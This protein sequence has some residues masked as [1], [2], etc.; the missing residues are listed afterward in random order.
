MAGPWEKYKQA[1]AR[2]VGPQDPK[3]PLDVE[4]KA[5]A[6]ARIPV[7]T[8]GDEL[9]NRQKEQDLRKGG[10]LGEQ[11]QK[12]LNEMRAQIG[13]A[14]E[15]VR[16]LSD[17]AGA[18]DRFGGGPTKAKWTKWGTAEEGG[19]LLDMLGALTIGMGIP[20]QQKEDWQTLTGLQNDAV[21]L[22]Q[23]A[24]K[25]PQTESDAVRMQLASLSPSKYPRVNAQTIGAAALNARLLQR[26]PSFYTNWAAKH[27]SINALDKSGRTVDQAWQA[28]SGVA[29]NAYKNDPRVKGLKAN[30]GAKPKALPNGWKIERA[31]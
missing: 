22:K 3:A 10:G 21:L 9:D 7:Q 16:L 24:Q 13:G 6:N 14:D 27:G 25:G 29:A 17:A 11:D 23:M 19:G 8:R 18:A 15:T 12:F 1:G 30:Q 20:Q 28:F 4:G 26:K 31:D 2:P 5:L